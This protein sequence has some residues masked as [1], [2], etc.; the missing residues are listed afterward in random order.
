MFV[1]GVILVRIFPYSVQMWENADQNNSE[2]GHFLRSVNDLS[3]TSNDF[4]AQL[5]QSIDLQ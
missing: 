1:F 5:I 3:V 4:A 2:Y